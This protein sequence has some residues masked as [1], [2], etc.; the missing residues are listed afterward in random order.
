MLML[1][2]I[3]HVEDHA[4]Y[5]SLYSSHDRARHHY[6]RYSPVGCRRLLERAG[7]A[8][9][10]SG[11]LFLSLLPARIGQVL[12]ER[13]RPATLLSSGVSGW[14]A[15]R[16]STKTLTRALIADGRISLLLNDRGL[17]LPGLSYWALCGSQ[18]T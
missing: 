5:E 17:S 7:L 3:E 13:V 16:P 15:G 9:L 2:V 4:R 18:A 1:D 14:N 8:V 12:I 11:G 10:S 6:R